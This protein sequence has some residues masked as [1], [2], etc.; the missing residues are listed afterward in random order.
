MD[1]GHA[2][3]QGQVMPT[4]SYLV[5]GLSTRNEPSYAPATGISLAQMLSGDR[6]AVI[7]RTQ[8]PQ[9]DWEELPR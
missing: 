7:V 6:E 4:Y 9:V 5:A 8:V 1:F 3:M 2:V